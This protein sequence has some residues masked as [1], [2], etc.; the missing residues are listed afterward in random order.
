MKDKI[1]SLATDF[2]S[3]NKALTLLML[4]SIQ[5]SFWLF[6]K[7]TYPLINSWLSSDIE[8]ILKSLNLIFSM[9]I[10]ISC[11]LCISY[12]FLKT[13]YYKFLSQEFDIHDK[14][15]LQLEL[16]SVLRHIIIIK[17]ALF[18][19][20]YYN[21]FIIYKELIIFTLLILMI[22]FFKYSFVNTP[23]ALGSN[24]LSLIAFIALTLIYILVGMYYFKIY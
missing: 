20:L 3:K 14:N 21:K 18:V 2:F 17:Y 6:P 10:I 16:L 5:L 11:T 4:F 24:F 13:L 9:I 7:E 15:V 8:N 1:L 12:N 23:L 22:A 19:I